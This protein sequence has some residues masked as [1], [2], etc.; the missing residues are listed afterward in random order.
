M[1]IRDLLL[2]RR[3]SQISTTAGTEGAGGNGGNVT[4]NAPSGFIVAVSNEN[5]DITAN[6]FSGS[7]GK[8]TINATGIYGI[9]PLT[10]QDL[11]R[12]RP[13]DLDPRLL[14]TSDI[15]AIS[16]ASPN[17]SGTVT[18]NTPDVDP[19]R[20]LVNLPAV[21]LDTE[22]SQV[23]QPRTAQNQSSFIITGRGGL[24]PNP[25]T[26]PLSSDTVV[27]DWVTLNPTS[28]NRFT[29]TV[30]NK[31][32]AIAPAPIV[33]ATGWMLNQKGEVVLTANALT[34]TPH[35]PWFN[36]ASCTTSKS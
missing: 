20:G 28:N 8:V 27:V 21:P 1:R 16:Q 36:P 33:E 19:N 2:L 3:G 26:E 25:R 4:I 5:S 17:L 23:C 31:P 14:T 15:T 24:P 34:S 6:A 32:T 29:P 12:L 22:V 13:N 30:T 9:A 35:S 7:G 18:V 11:E 10:R